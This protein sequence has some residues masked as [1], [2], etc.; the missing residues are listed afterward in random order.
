MAGN[1][2]GK[3]KEH[4]EGVHRNFDWS[5]HHLQESLTL[6]AEQIRVSAIA[7]NP[8]ITDTEIQQQVEEYPLYKAVLK[9]GES[10]QAL[11]VI[12]MDVYSHL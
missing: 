1:T 4:L 10:I 5:I 11:D 7:E 9:L 6:I 3:L 8:N 2:R 12:S